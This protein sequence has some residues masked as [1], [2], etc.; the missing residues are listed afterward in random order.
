MKKQKSTKRALLMSA[1]SLLLCLS[2]LVGTTFAWFTDSVTSGKNRITAGNLDVELE[3]ANVVDGKITGWMGVAGEKDIFDPNALWEPGHVEVVYLKV[4]NKGSLA[5]KYHLG[6]NVAG[7]VS[8]INVAGEEFYLSDYLVFKA[9]EM[10]DALTTYSDREAASVAAGTEMGL[11]DYNSKTTVLEPNGEDYVALI[12]CMPESVGNEANYK[13]GTAAPFIELGIN[14]FATQYTEEEDSYG[15]DYD[16]D[17]WNIVYDENGL[18]GAVASGLTMIKLGADIVLTEPLIIPAQPVTT[19]SLRRTAPSGLVLDLGGFTLTLPDTINEPAIINNGS[20]TLQ[21][22]TVAGDIDSTNGAILQLD[23]NAQVG[24]IT[25]T[26]ESQ[27]LVTNYSSY[28]DVVGTDGAD[29]PV[30]PADGYV[31]VEV[32]DESGKIV[33]TIVVPGE[34]ADGISAITNISELAAALTNG[35]NYVLANDLEVESTLTV[36]N[37]VEVTLDLGNK[38]IAGNLPGTGNKDMFLVKGKLTVKN[39]AVELEV[40]VN[41]GWGAMSA[42]FDITAGGIVNLESVVADNKGG[43]DMNFVAHLNNWGEVTLNVKKSTLKAT[44]VPVRVFNSGYDMNNVTI[45]DSTLDGGNYAFWVHNYTVAD[46]GTA[47][48]AEAQKALLN[49]N[50]FGKGNTFVTGKTVPIRYGFTNS[51]LAT[52]E[53]NKLITTADELIEALKAGKDIVLGADITVTGAWDNRY[54]GAKTT[55]P[56]VIDGMGHTL[57]FTGTISDGGNYHSVFRFEAD[58]T[59][60]NLTIDVSEAAG[61][62][63][64]L[65]AISAKADLT[66]DNCTF[67]GNAN[68]TNTRGIS[69]GEGAGAAIAEQDV[70]IANSVFKNWKRGIT[71]NENAQDAKTVTVK[72]NTFENAA[73]YVSAFKQVEFTGNKMEN[74]EVNVKSY[75]APETLN[76]V[77]E[78]NILDT[79]KNNYLG[80]KAY[81]VNA[82][83]LDAALKKGYDVVLNSDITIEAKSSNGYGVNGITVDGQI[84]DGNGHTLTVTKAN[85]T[86]DSAIYIKSGTVKNI[87]VAGSMRGIFTSDAA[88]GDI[89]LNDVTFKDVIYTF[90]S[91]GTPNV[92]EGGVYITNCKVNGWTSF[93]DTHEEVVFTDCSFAKGSGYQFAR[94]YN[95]A[96]FVNCSFAEGFEME[97]VA[98]VTFKNCTINGAP[99]TAENLATLVTSNIANATVIG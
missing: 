48:K 72:D 87:T 89:Y 79:T 51:I 81:V 40:P 2:M 71:D 75:T 12:V 31:N 43:T 15:P 9:V 84:L 6:V 90:N 26:D 35:G 7:E 42:I 25:V 49:L 63:Q 70:S 61:S 27:V 47:D 77:E 86:W 21:N 57:K 11:K 65:R 67:I 34:A 88:N 38:K 1:L 28:E 5:L 85:T 36:P 37:G 23:N 68:L 60:K 39:G 46:F 98:A 20:L 52:A 76:V 78:N 69:Y 3:Y 41:Q 50:I 10:P 19:Y 58:A 29:I 95:V 44:Y 22:G 99:L 24:V 14:L 94:P 83:A 62:G 73:V 66:V 82:D 97:P 54:T 64:R 55:K 30:A 53:G 17:S 4:S 8:G 45:E 32:K 96:Q 56:I 13:A 18:R 74:A 33:G 91:D 92:R 93:S 59:V 16:E 80:K